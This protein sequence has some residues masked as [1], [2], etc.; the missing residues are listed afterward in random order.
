MLGRVAT[1]GVSAGGAVNKLQSRGFA[2]NLKEIQVRIQSTENIRKITASMKMVSAA[3]LRG[4]QE[5]LDQGRPFGKTVEKLFSATPGEDDTPVPPAQSPVYVVVSSD[6]GLCGGVNS[7]V[8]KVTKAAVDSDVANGLS[9]KI[10]VIGDKGSGPLVRTHGEY[11]LGQIN[12]PWKTP[13][14]FDKACIIASR[15]ME[16]C[17]EADSYNIVFNRFVS[18][19]VYETEVNKNV[20]FAGIGN[21]DDESAAEKPFPLNKYEGELESSEEQLLNLT[22]YG[23]AVQ[24][25]GCFIENAT[26]EQSSRMTAMENASKNASEM[27]EKLTIRYNRARQAKITTELIEI[28]SGAESLEG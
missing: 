15:I 5:R 22:E 11:L 27:V 21:V 17:P 9:P 1:R 14:N 7:A 19:I 2:E 13:V 18:A 12:E 4:D 23:L 26:S 16:A 25:Y 20:N 6:R 24:L 10:F 8:A 28:I 3:K